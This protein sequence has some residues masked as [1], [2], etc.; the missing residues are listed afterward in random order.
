[1]V[2]NPRQAECQK[3]CK[4]RWPSVKSRAFERLPIFFDRI[5]AVKVVGFLPKNQWY[6][7]T[8]SQSVAQIRFHCVKVFLRCIFAAK[9]NSGN[10]NVSGIM[11]DI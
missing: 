7:I 3:N 1:M 9:L 6:K 2:A 5:M 8:N 11:Y 10:M 4:I